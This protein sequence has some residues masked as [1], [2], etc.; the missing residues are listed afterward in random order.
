MRDVARSGYKASQFAISC[1]VPIKQ[2]LFGQANQK[3]PSSS[4]VRNER[5]AQQRGAMRVRT[6]GPDCGREPTTSRSAATLAGGGDRRRERAA[7]QA[8]P[9][10]PTA[11]WRAAA[12]TKEAKARTPQRNLRAWRQRSRRRRGEQ[13]SA[14]SIR[15]CLSQQ[16]RER[17]PPP[18]PF[19]EHLLLQKR[20]LRGATLE[21][22]R[23]FKSFW[24]VV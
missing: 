24:P 10:P 4:L 16:P 13:R 11:G 20:R 19:P 21:S 15:P 14:A 6:G 8:G 2:V 17:T 23:G 22:S 1:S 9:H 18:P 12:G 5:S 7:D 3:S